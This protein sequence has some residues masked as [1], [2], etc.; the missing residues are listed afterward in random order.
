[1][2][3][4]LSDENAFD[5]SAADVAGL[6]GALVDLEVILEAAPAVDP[7]DAGAVATDAF[8]Q[9][10]AHSYQESFGVISA[11]AVGGAQGVQ[12]GLVQ[13]FIGVDVAHASQEVLVHEQ[14]FELAFMGLQALEENIGGEGFI[15]R[16]GAEFV[17]GFCHVIHQ[18]HPP[19][20]A[21]VD[22][23]QALPADEVEN[24]A[25]VGLQGQASCFHAHVT[26]HAQVDH[27]RILVEMNEDVFAAP[28]QALDALTGQPGV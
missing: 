8:P 11:K 19:E 21:R 14:G 13:G 1:M 7:I 4:A 20:F 15:Q 5:F 18:P 9:N 17:Q 2:C 6:A 16:F 28:S 22:E 25:I 24:G 12:F 10:I 23:D 3:A 27:Q 26:A